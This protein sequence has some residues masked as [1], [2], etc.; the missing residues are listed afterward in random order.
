VL[1]REAFGEP[2]AHRQA[3]AFT[4]ADIAIELAGLRLVVWRAASRLDQGRDAARLIAHARQLTATHAA[5]IGSHA[6]QLLGGHGFVKEFDN[7]RWYRDL[8]GAGV[9]EGVLLT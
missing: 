2:I 4:V 7:E 8:R 6:V 1:T 9:L 3:V 5:Q